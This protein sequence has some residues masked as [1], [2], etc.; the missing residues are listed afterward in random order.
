MSE[1]RIYHN[2]R[3]SKSR[4]ALELLYKHDLTPTVTEYLK[5]PPAPAELRELLGML[6]LPVTEIVRTGEPAFRSLNIDLDNT[7]A[8]ITALAEHPVLLQRP[9]V[10]HGG[11]AVIG[12]PPEN[13]LQLIK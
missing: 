6:D 13:V 8:V 2:P 3:C 9:I 4:A 5:H 12:R 10:V 11:R 1:W 7:D